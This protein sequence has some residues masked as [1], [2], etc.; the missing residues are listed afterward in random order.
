MRESRSHAGPHFV[1]KIYF[2]SPGRFSLGK[3]AAIRPLLSSK[4]HQSIASKVASGSI[5]SFSKEPNGVTLFSLYGRNKEDMKVT[6]QVLIDCL[7]DMAYESSGKIRKPLEKYRKE[8]P[9][10]EKAIS[11]LMNEK[12]NVTVRLEE[13]KKIVRYRNTKDA[14]ESIQEFDKVLQL[15]EIEIIGIQ[16]KLDMIKQQKDK[17]Q[18]TNGDYPKSTADLL[19]QMRLTQEIELTGAFARKN[20]GESALKK[21]TDFLSLVEKIK[22][23]KETLGEKRKQ[24][25]SL[26]LKI[27]RLEKI[28]AESFRDMRPV[29]LVDDTIFIYPTLSKQQ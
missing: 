5:G 3:G 22:G 18:K 23:I 27:P 28:L 29:E 19:F 17:L 8:E 20:A 14:Q 7:N 13:I 15:I 11:Q 2:K 1:A 24:L 6:A 16:A 25:A 26:Q 9:E 21:A 4:G 12:E 10:L